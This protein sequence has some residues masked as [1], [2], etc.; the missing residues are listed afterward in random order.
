MTSKD[1]NFVLKGLPPG[2][3]TIEAWQEHYG[4]VDQQVTIGPKESK[5]VTLTLRRI[6]DTGGGLV[7]SATPRSAI[8]ARSG[9][10]RLKPPTLWLA[11]SR[12]TVKASRFSS[13]RHF[14]A[15]LQDGP[16]RRRPCSSCLACYFIANYGV[17]SELGKGL[18]HDVRRAESGSPSLRYPYRRLHRPAFT[19]G[20]LVTS[21]DAAD[22]VP[23][24]PLAYGRLIPPLV[25]GIRYEF[26]HRVAAAL[27]AISSRCLRFG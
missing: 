26:A 12:K 8:D 27:V 10:R 3:Y 20:A 14:Y 16:R 9:W 22:S 13:R 1:G 11:F 5:K 24:W 23:D 25:G 2:T 6:V 21:N 4:V 18:G 15:E 19:A 7:E 17:P